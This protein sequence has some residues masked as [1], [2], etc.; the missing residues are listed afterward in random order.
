MSWR[1]GLAYRVRSLLGRRRARLER[2]E[3]M[4]FH[5][6]MEVESL[7]RA[8]GAPAS[9]RGATTAPLA[10]ARAATGW[11]PETI[12][13][14]AR[15]AVRSLSRSP[16]YTLTAGATLVAAIG[17]ATA[18][19]TVLSALFLQPLPFPRDEELV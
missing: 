15:Y 12:V 5:A 14:D 7:R 6:Q 3:E 8:T 4:A 19:A 1:D 13:Q 10:D 18:T 11:H 2:S 16:A 17:V 9:A